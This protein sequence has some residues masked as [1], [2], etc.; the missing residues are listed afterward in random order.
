MSG[1]IGILNLDGAPVDRRLLARMTDFLVFR[2]PDAQNSWIDGAAGFGHTL[3]KT[4]YES[5]RERQP[6]TLDEK[7]WIVADARVDARSDLIAKLKARGREVAADVPDVE[8]IL[9]AYGVWQEDCVERLLGDFAFGVWDATRRRLFLARDHMG[10]KPLYYSHIGS[11][12]IFSNTLD[13]M[14][15]H[16]LVSDRLND[17][18]VADFLLFDLNQDKATTTFADIQRI[19]PAHCAVWSETGL[20]LRRY[21]TLPIDEPVYY[22][23]LDDYVDRFKELLKAAVGDRLRTDRVGIFMSGGIDSPTLAATAHELLRNRSIN[24]GV[25]AFTIAYDGYG[26]ERYYAGLV[27]AKLG[28]P[29][30]FSGWTEDTFDPDW[31]STSFHT[32]EPVPYPARLSVDRTYYQGMAA[33]SR[34]AFFGEGPDN[35]LRYEWSTYLSYLIRGRRI[36]RLLYDLGCQAVLDPRLFAVAVRRILKR[37]AP[38]ETE[39]PFPDWFNADFEKHFQLRARWQQLQVQLRSPHPIRPVHQ[40]VRFWPGERNPV[41][42]VRQPGPQ[43]PLGQPGPTHRGPAG[44]APPGRR[45]NRDRDRRD[46]R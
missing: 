34:V 22:R 29:I 26:E 38:D 45:R 12:V 27:A 16:P 9:H 17:L 3:L 13:C 36:G 35:A 7:V 5:E 25:R 4:T 37:P 15:Q 2:G 46:V 6:F 10:V 43:C 18:G 24:S 19:P 28:I 44:R 20:D 21:W 8:L 40:P 42:S 31:Q 41:R 33:H 14:R 1:I 23:K 30:E 11:C 39:S 32:P